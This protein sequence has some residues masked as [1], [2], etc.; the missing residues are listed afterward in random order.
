M[1]EDLRESLMSIADRA[2]A[3]F[4]P[5]GGWGGRQ[6]D[7]NR[8]LRAWDEHELDQLY[9]NG[10]S[11]KDRR[12]LLCV[13]PRLMQLVAEA[14]LGGK[15]SEDFCKY[16]DFFFLTLWLKQAEVWDWP[17]SEREVIN[18]YMQ[19]LFVFSLR[20]S[21]SVDC[22]VVEFLMTSSEGTELIKGVFEADRSVAASLG[23][24]RCIDWIYYRPADIPK[25]REPSAPTA[26]LKR[27]FMR[28]EIRWRLEDSFFKLSEAREQ[29]EISAVITLLDLWS[30]V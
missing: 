14:R 8:P 20:H 12:D 2:Y 18:D 19:S 5:Y 11:K 1:A 26:K 9:L 28:P 24:A 15:S 7:T 3:V 6:V 25:D 29:A 27:Y 22:D 21:A 10:L 16:R 23:L 17:L 30:E 13:L 4:R